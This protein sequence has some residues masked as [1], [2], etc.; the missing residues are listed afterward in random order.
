MRRKFGIFSVILGIV[1]LV[2]LVAGR[3][4]SKEI[5][6]N[7]TGDRPERL[8]TKLSQP[9]GSYVWL[10]GRVQAD[11]AVHL[12]RHGINMY[13]YPVSGYEGRVFVV[14]DGRPLP[15]NLLE[16]KANFSGQLKELERVP[17]ARFAADKLNLRP[18]V[19]YFAVNPG[20]KPDPNTVYLYGAFLAVGIAFAFPI[21]MEVNMRRT[22]AA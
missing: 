8:D 22:R 19:E 5:T 17:F 4:A 13:F 3:F 14:S 18:G 15:G 6:Y 12:D 10:Q 16:G 1:F 9:P 7:L 11:K 2:F 21:A 20:K